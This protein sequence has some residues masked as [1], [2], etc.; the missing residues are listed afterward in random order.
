MVMSLPAETKEKAK[1]ARPR[2]RGSRGPTPPVRG[3]WPEGPEGVGNAAYERPL[4]EGAHRRR[5]LGASLVTFC[6]S[7]K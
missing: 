1:V 4:R 5:P 6:A 7:R 3:R 2:N